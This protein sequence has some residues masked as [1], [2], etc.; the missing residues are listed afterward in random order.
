MVRINLPYD[1]QTKSLPKE[2][3][4]VSNLAETL[5]VAS[6][7]VGDSEILPASSILSV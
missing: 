7:N 4:P 2:M 3:N 1:E 6:N 5:N